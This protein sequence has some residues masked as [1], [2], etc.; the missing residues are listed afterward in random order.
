MIWT[1]KITEAL[2]KTSR[3]EKNAMETA[4]KFV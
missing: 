4:R 3:N 2:E 1:N